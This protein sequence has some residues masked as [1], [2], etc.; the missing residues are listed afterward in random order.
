MLHIIPLC[1][2]RL[3]TFGFVCRW[4]STIFGLVFLWIQ[5]LLD[6]FAF[7]NFL[8]QYL[9][10]H[11]H[12]SKL[13]LNSHRFF[14]LKKTQY[15]FWKFGWNVLDQT[16]YQQPKVGF[17]CVYLLKANFDNWV[18]VLTTIPHGRWLMEPR[19][20]LAI[21]T[22]YAQLRVEFD[23]LNLSP[24]DPKCIYGE[25]FQSNAN[26]DTSFRCRTERMQWTLI[27]I[28]INIF[29]FRYS[30]EWISGR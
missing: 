14:N 9:L 2:S 25:I 1:R 26:A 29:L 7:F 27:F 22:T 19:R 20:H 21:N 5:Q 3:L 10:R 18:H 12:D 16:I 4:W 28:F 8:H 23:R 30:C 11:H 24:I 15:C 13:C 6:F 17:T